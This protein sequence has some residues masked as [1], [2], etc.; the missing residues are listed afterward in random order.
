MAVP[1]FQA[2][3]AVGNAATGPKRQR[4]RSP[5]AGAAPASDRAAILYGAGTFQVVTG[6]IVN[7]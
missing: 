4:T 1:L 7:V 3:G 5:R 6:A 2:S